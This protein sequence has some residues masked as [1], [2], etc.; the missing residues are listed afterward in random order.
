MKKINVILYVIILAKICVAED[1]STLSPERCN[2]Y[3]P[4]PE[5]GTKRCILLEGNCVLKE[6]QEF[7]NCEAFPSIGEGDDLKKCMNTNEG[8][9]LIKCSELSTDNCEDFGYDD[10]GLKCLIKMSKVPDEPIFSD[11]CQLQGCTDLP[12]EYC[13]WL[14]NDEIKCQDNEE[15]TGCELIKCSELKPGQC[16]RVYYDN[17]TIQCLEAEDGKRCEIKKCSDYKSNE[18]S[19][20]LP[21]RIWAKCIPEENGCE[22]KECMDLTSPN[23]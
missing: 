1:C 7:T 13:S 21:S 19:K 10:R 18:C 6:C 16:N 17:Y 20:Y 15:Y 3:V 8:C 11:Y 23:C 9:R 4:T 22:E 2:D 5:D 14:S 12:A